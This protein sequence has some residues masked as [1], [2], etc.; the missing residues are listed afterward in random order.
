MGIEK[1]AGIVLFRNDSDK[2]EFLLLNY[3]QG[4]WDFVKGKIEQNETSH[5]AAI[6][7]TRE[8]T[9]I[10]N[11]EFID[12]FEESVEYDFRFRKED[13]HKK[14]IFFLAKTDE[15]NI[16]LSHEHNDY[17]WLEYSNALKKT[18]F[19]NAKNVLSKANQF[20]SSTC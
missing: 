19:E 20:L 8:E 12:G 13:I 7:E 9:G 14:V 11:I 1:S 4:H 5:E 2:N 17:L 3:P 16:K 10:T 18:T 15:K 6:R